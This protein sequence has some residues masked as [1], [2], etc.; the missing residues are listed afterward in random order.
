MPAFLQVAGFACL[1]FAFTLLTRPR[2]RPSPAAY[3]WA[4]AVDAL[5]IVFVLGVLIVWPAW[6]LLIPLT[7]WGST[8]ALHVLRLRDARVMVRVL[9]ANSPPSWGPGRRVQRDGSTYGYDGWPDDATRPEDHYPR[10]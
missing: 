8:L 2:E 4:I 9:E 3:L 6:W 5:C 7:I 1:A 10:Y